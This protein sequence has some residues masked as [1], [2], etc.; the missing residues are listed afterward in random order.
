[1]YGYYALV[2]LGVVS[3]SLGGKFITPIQLIQFILC[4]LSIL[5]E[6]VNYEKCQS[7]T[8]TLVWVIVQYVV[9]FGFFAKIFLDKKRERQRAPANREKKD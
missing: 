5:Y 6:A 8:K 7:N 4:M 3:R 2:E 1:M 9:F